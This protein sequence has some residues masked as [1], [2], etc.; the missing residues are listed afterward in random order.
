MALK[1]QIKKA[2]SENTIYNVVK[3]YNPITTTYMSGSKFMTIEI[4]IKRKN[5]K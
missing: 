5:R 4:Q 3:V 2:I 1:S